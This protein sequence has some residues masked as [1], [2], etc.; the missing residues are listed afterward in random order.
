[1]ETAEIEQNGCLFIMNGGRR[2]TPDGDFLTL[3]KNTPSISEEQIKVKII[4]ILDF[5]DL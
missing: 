1:M 4:T 3:L 2:R 5:E